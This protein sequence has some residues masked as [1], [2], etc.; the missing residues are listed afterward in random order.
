M[1]TS[2]D[3]KNSF[4]RL[5]KRAAILLCLSIALNACTIAPL[6]S[7][8]VTHVVLM[9]LKHPQSAADRATLIRAA[10]SL[11]II[12]GV[13][14][15]EAGGAPTLPSGVERNFD[16]AV[17]ITFRDRVALERYERDPRHLTAARRYL[18]PLVRRYVVY[19]LSNR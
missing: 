6:A 8:T 7:P 11:R 3:W 12:P 16:L 10:Q 14:R 17:V 5:G 9:W 1:K 13:L 18:K 4:G 19:N 15:V 2:A